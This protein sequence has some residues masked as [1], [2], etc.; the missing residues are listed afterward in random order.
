LLHFNTRRPLPDRSNGLDGSST[1][2]MHRRLVH[3]QYRHDAKQV[4]GFASRAGV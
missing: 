1:A 4:R 3:P 2:V